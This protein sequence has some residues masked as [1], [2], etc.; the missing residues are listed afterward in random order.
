[1]LSLTVTDHASRFVLLWEALE[2]AREDVAFRP[3]VVTRVAGSDRLVL[4]GAAGFEP[5]TPSSRT[6]CAT[7]PRIQ[8]SSPS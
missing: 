4:V 2:T 3:E 8:D 6:R 7:R 5:V 1:V